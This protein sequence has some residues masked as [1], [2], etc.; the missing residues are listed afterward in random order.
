MK[1]FM[2]SESQSKIFLAL[3]QFSIENVEIF[4]AAMMDKIK[5]L[6]HASILEIHP[7]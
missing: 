7:T 4:S 6:V 3:A 2:M 5:I 1:S